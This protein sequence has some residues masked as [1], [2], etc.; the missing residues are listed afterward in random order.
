[1]VQIVLALITKSNRKRYIMTDLIDGRY[2]LT[3][4]FTLFLLILLSDENPAPCL[5]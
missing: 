5:D 1:M 3:F 4:Q 2:D